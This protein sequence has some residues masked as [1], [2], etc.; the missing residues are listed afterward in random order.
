MCVSEKGNRQLGEGHCVPKGPGSHRGVRGRRTGWAEDAPHCPCALLKTHIKGE[1]SFEWK[2]R[3][4]LEA[5]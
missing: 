1:L 2:S 4:T 3:N 5:A